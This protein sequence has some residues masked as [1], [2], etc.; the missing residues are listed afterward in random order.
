MLDSIFNAIGGD[1]VSSLTEKAGIDLDQAKAV[2]PIA[3]E[4][5]Q[6]GL[7]DEV[8]SGNISGILGMLNS[9]G[10]SLQSNSLFGNLKGMLLQNLLSKLGLP[11]S[12]A[13]LVAGTGLTSIIGGASNFLSGDKPVEKNDLMSKLDL[14][15]MAGD[16]AKGMLKDKLGGLGK[17]FG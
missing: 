3:Q 7:M 11:E 6:T 14:G 13:G 10:D 16:M 2:L 12:V 9:S 5:V 1:V 4:T 8:K 17:L 15:G